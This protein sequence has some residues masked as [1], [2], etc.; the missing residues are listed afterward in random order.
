MD[1]KGYVSKF[2]KCVYQQ[3]YLR[4]AGRIREPYLIR[5]DR[6]FTHPDTNE[7]TVSFHVVNKR[8]SQESSVSDFVKSDMIY[9]IDPRIVFDMGQQFGSHTEKLNLIEKKSPSLKTRCITSL[10]RVFVDE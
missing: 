8:V 1:V 5:I 6:I 10:K 3:I 4:I 2:F 7:L 9:L